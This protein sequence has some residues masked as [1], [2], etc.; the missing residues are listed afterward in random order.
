MLLLNKSCR[1]SG[2]FRTAAAGRL[3]HSR[4]SPLSACMPEEDERPGAGDRKVFPPKGSVPARALGPGQA[5]RV[6]TGAMLPSGCD[7]VVPWEATD[8]GTPQLNRY[9]RL[10]VTVK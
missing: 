5:A 7:C 3:V 8:N 9:L 10:I 1:R 2:L 6:M 4:N